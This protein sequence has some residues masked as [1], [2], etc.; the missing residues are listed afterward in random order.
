[1]DRVCTDERQPAKIVIIGVGNLLLKDEG[2]GIHVIEELQKE[3]LPSEVMVLDGGVGGIGLL[4]F[5]R[6]ASKVLLIDAADIDL[7]PGAVV[8]FSPEEVKGKK[9]SPRFSAHEVGLWE[10]LELAKALDHY[11][12]EV[13]IIG[14]Q[15]KEISWGTD[16]TPEVQ[17]AVPKVLEAVFKEIQASIT[18]SAH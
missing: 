5:F 2:V 10:V 3:D 6:G 12:P 1:M 17:A 8:R 14:V 15:P 18:R 11:P 4:D 13:I 9:E 16:L 7:E